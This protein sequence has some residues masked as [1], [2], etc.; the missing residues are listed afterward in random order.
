MD[1]FRSPM[2]A[3]VGRIRMRADRLLDFATLLKGMWK[4]GTKVERPLKGAYTSMR[5]ISA[6][7]RLF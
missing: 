1:L 3:E 6:F 7:S 2:L 4:G 5:C